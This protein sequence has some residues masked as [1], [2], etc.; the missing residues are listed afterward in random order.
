MRIRAAA[1]R[2]ADEIAEAME[3]QFAQQ[4]EWIDQHRSPLGKRRHLRLVRD[5][6]LPAKKDGRLVLVRAVDIDAYLAQRPA[7]PVSVEVDDDEA[8][9]EGM[10]ARLGLQP[11]LARRRA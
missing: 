4:S 8:E 2:F 6:K 11:T 9:L 3:S 1:E 10:A 5:G 7:I